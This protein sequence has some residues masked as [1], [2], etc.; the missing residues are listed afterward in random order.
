MVL[1][2]NWYST[3]V[4]CGWHDSVQDTPP[5][6][7]ILIRH[8]RFERGVLRFVAMSINFRDFCCDPLMSHTRRIYSYLRVVPAAM[9]TISLYSKWRFSIAAMSTIS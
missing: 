1:C 9:I 6:V 7:F 8:S 2:N 3:Y 5:Y 4:N